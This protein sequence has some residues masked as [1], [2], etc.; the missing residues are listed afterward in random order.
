MGTN[1]HLIRAVQS[2][3]R[4][5]SSSGNFDSLLSDVL[6][7]SVEAVGAAGGTVYIHEPATHR[8]RF[9]HVLP[10]EVVSRLPYHDIADDFGVAG[11][12]FQTRK[13]VITHPKQHDVT[14]H[15]DIEAATGVPISSMLTVPLMMEDEAPIGVIQI[16]NKAEGDF[17][18]S[19]IAVM[20]T[21]AAVSTMAYLNS[22]L[23]DQESQASSLLGMGK[24]GHDI[25]N[26]AA[27]LY[28]NISY[29]ELAIRGLNQQL[30]KENVSE[31]CR[32]Y[33]ESLSSMQDDLK[34]SVDRIVG[35]SRLIGDLSA[36]RKLRPA[37]KLTSLA[38]TIQTS[39]AY[40]EAQGRRHLVALCYDIDK[41]APPLLHDDL[42]VFRIVQNLVGNAIKAVRETVPDDWFKQI[43]SRSEG[44]VLGEVWIRY[45]FDGKN[46][47]LEVQDNGPGMPQQT[48]D[49][50]LAGNA[51]SHWD[52]AT[53]SGWGTKIV[54]ELAATHQATV[55]I[56]S[57]Q[58]KG[59][60]FRVK[61]PH[62][63]E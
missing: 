20:D 46:H 12:V 39:A 34:S 52:K 38:D 16:I 13:T 1:E 3:T 60:T 8:L 11:Q 61:F 25:G 15:P 9:Q 53:G 5:L 10:N 2:A 51:R 31:T 63:T 18:D 57:E 56:D 36:G 30:D 4:R 6:S 49:R 40:L 19:D 14:H 35:Y 42:Y 29:S 47:I 24:V 43:E 26:L 28:A 45:H 23:L 50:I 33:V 62:I 44:T 37:M 17:T 32:M 48:V 27:S 7:I 58:G 41:N 22:R 21:L 54:L 55:E 59:S